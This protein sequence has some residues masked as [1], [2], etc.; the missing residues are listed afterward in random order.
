M[1]PVVDLQRRLRELG[2]IRMGEQRVSSRG[3]SYPAAL[4]R[5]RF[6]SPSRG[7]LDGMVATVGGQVREWQD[8]PGE[9]P[10]W[11]LYSD[12]SE[13]VA[14]C[15]PVEEPYSQWY[16]L[17]S[18]AGCQR[19]CNGERATVAVQQGDQV[20]MRERSCLCNPDERECKLTTRASVI[21]PWA[22][23]ARAR[24]AGDA[25][26][27]AGD[28]DRR[29]PGAAHVRAGVGADGG[30]AG[31]ALAPSH[32]GGR[33]RAVRA[34]GGVQRPGRRQRRRGLGIGARASLR[35]GRQARALR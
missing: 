19:R 18:A 30:A 34:V 24:A 29:H 6:T 7:I 12:A 22:P 25:V 9:A 21:L 28:R 17:W 31:H 5:F 23:Q 14:A 4:D 35:R 26:R 33:S 27:G 8:A 10:Q 13:I 1:S 11:E 20:V 3:K 16:E 2:R 15:P 32:P